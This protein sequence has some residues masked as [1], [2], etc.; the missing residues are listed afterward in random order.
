MN[1]IITPSSSPSSNPSSNP[2]SY[3]DNLAKILSIYQLVLPKR[4]PV[5]IPNI[6]RKGLARLFHVLGYTI[7]VEVGT[8][9][10]KYAQTLCEENP[11]LHLFCVDIWKNYPFYRDYVNRGNMLDESRQ[12]WNTRMKPYNATPIEK[13]SMEAVNDFK[14]GELDFVYIDAN[15]E[16]PFVTEDIFYWSRKVRAGGII[17]GHDFYETKSVRSRCH[18]VPAVYGYTRAFWIHPWFLLG[19]KAINPGEIRERARSWFWV[20][21]DRQ[22]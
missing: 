1:P 15:H 20:K 8:E 13:Y 4:S 14:D 11:D 5:E 6:G 19:T 2:S 3:A 22:P 17:S 18:V 21:D 12:I 7:G 10:G 16:L 9:Q